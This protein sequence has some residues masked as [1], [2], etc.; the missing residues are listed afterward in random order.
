MGGAH[1]RRHERAERNPTTVTELCTGDE[2]GA[3]TDVT[4]R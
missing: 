1:D 2:L 4:G 3:G